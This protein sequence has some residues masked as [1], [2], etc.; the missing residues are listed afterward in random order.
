MKIYRIFIGLLYYMSGST[1]NFL[2][3]DELA[4]LSNNNKNVLCGALTGFL[5]KSTLGI[6]PACVGSILGGAMM[7]SL[8]QIIQYLNQKE[9]I[10][11]E[12]RF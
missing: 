11:F 5:Y 4:F 7:G 3:E 12:M 10:A 1:L 6:I 8:T 9:Y 2:F